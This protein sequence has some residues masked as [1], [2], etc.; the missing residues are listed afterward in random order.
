[1]TPLDPNEEI[2]ES[3]VMN[4]TGPDGVERRYRH[5]KLG[6]DHMKNGKFSN[7]FIQGAVRNLTLVKAFFGSLLAVAAVVWGVAEW[8][9]IPQLERK[10]E[11]TIAP[12]AARVEAAE[13][14]MTEH[15]LEVAEKSRLYPTRTELKEDLDEIKQLLRDAE[16]R[17]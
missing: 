11:R 10:I 2:D 13:Q 7:N 6:L 16:N 1:M 17:Q 3:E 15:R 14:A 5:R 8:T 4:V 12:L 9:V